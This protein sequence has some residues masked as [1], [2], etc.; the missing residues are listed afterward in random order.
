ML[1]GSLGWEEAGC[2]RVYMVVL[3]FLYGVKLFKTF[4]QRISSTVISQS[5]RVTKNSW[6]R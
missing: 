4:A 6:L 2:S 3:Q 5:C 1:S